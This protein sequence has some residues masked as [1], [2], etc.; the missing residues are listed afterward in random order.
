MQ[1]TAEFSARFYGPMEEIKKLSPVMAD[2]YKRNKKGSDKSYRNAVECLIQNLI[3]PKKTPTCN[4]SDSNICIGFDGIEA[5][6][7]EDGVLH[8]LW[9][10]EEAVPNVSM[11]ILDRN[12][13]YLNYKFYSDFGQCVMRNSYHG[14]VENYPE[15]EWIP[16]EWRELKSEEEFDYADMVLMGLKNTFIPYGLTGKKK[17]KV[18]S[19]IQ[20]YVDEHAEEFSHYVPD[21]CNSYSDMYSI[22]E[23]DIDEAQNII[24]Q[25]KEIIKH[26]YSSTIQLAIDIIL[27]LVP[28]IND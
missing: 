20:E 6:E 7:M 15:L 4:N 25:D 26:N 17:E 27:N 22:F 28:R 1:W 18:L 12:E 5:I 2:I 24:E 11:A 21:G 9:E 14:N 3:F 16:Q 19:I 23:I 13:N 10:L 8:A